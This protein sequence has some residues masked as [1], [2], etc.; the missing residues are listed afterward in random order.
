MPWLPFGGLGREEPDVQIRDTM[1]MC[2]LCDLGK[3]L[4]SGLRVPTHTVASPSTDWSGGKEEVLVLSSVTAMALARTSL[5][6]SVKS[7]G[8]DSPWRSLS[9]GSC[10]CPH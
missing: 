4:T 3:Q 9:D 1:A 2:D 6:S 10:H 7:K 5:F 8:V